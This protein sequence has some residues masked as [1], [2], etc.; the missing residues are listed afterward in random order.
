LNTHTL[1]K[2]LAVC[3]LAMLPTS[4]FSA[5]TQQTRHSGRAKSL[6]T[7]KLNETFAFFFDAQIR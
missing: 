7:F 1:K 3:F 6:N 5:N 2:D 4:H